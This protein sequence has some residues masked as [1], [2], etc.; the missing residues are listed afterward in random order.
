MSAS[1]FHSAYCTVLH[2]SCIKHN[3]Y[4]YM[5]LLIRREWLPNVPPRRNH[6]R[7]NPYLPIPLLGL[8]P[9]I[10]QTTQ[11]KTT[12]IYRNSFLFGARRAVPASNTLWLSNSISRSH[13]IT[14]SCQSVEKLKA[15]LCYCIDKEAFIVY[16]GKYLICRGIRICNQRDEL[17]PYGVAVLHSNI[18]VVFSQ[19]W[20]FIKLMIKMEHT[21]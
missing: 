5:V 14:R 9:M 12:L 1:H 4:K 15:L 17:F 16:K 3:T 18:Q 19:L 7:Y 13:T 8:T 11:R 21:L 6:S 2:C 20:N 10:S